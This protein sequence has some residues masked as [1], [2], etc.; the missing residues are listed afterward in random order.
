MFWEF[1]RDEERFQE[2]VE[3]VTATTVADRDYVHLGVQVCQLIMEK[4][5]G[6]KFRQA[7][8]RWFQQ[9]F[10]AKDDIRAVSIEKWLSTFAFMCEIFSCVLIS[11]Q[12]ITILGNAV[13]SGIEFLLEQPDRDDDEVDCICSSLKLCGSSLET[14]NQKKMDGLMNTFRRIVFAKNSSCRVRCLVLEIIEL[15]AM[16]WND[17]EKKL[18]DFYVDGLM[19]AVAEDEAESDTQP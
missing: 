13:Y 1:G 8:M 15:R 16:G 11:E 12:P 9:Q 4:P 5:N 14:S 3:L 17:S 2:A 6:P 7:L 19:D 10:N 18:E